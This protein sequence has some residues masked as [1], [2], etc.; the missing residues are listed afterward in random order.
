MQGISEV[1]PN[2]SAEV[3]LKPFMQRRFERDRAIVVEGK[4]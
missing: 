2:H 4:N 1:I 3:T